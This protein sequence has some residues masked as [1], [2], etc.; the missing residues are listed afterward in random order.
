MTTRSRLATIAIGFAAT[1]LT[2][3]CAMQEQ[4]TM[5]SL[6]QPINCA[7]VEGDIRAL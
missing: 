3:G 7:T 5:Q 1:A 6:N 2:A 4:Q